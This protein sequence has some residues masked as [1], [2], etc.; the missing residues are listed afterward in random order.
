MPFWTF[1]SDSKLISPAFSFNWPVQPQT[2][3]LYCCRIGL[4]LK[5]LI[6]LFS[7]PLLLHL[8]SP[9][10][11]SRDEQLTVVSTLFLYATL[12]PNPLLL[13]PKKIS[14]DYISS[15]CFLLVIGRIHFLRSLS[16][17][18]YF[19]DVAVTSLPPAQFVIVSHAQWLSAN[20]FSAR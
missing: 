19:S 16:H 3:Q 2:Y 11:S 1:W 8:S 10:T 7:T 5:S 20:D 13:S 4:S 17:V 15:F 9:S 18:L 6:L 14:N 12:S